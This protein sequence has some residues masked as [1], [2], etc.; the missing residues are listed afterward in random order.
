MLQIETRQ[1]DEQTAAVVLRG[2]IMLGLESQQVED[3]IAG[4]LRQG[5]KRI[6]CDLSGVT[7]I[8]STGIGRFISSL[9][10]VMQAGARLLMAGAEG[11][12]RKAFHVTLLDTVFQFFASVEEARSALH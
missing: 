6:I 5:K 12:V 7:H 4:L 10:M 3:Q 2:K 8:D 9:N 11:S 1:L